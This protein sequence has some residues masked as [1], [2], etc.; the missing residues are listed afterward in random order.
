[1]LMSTVYVFTT[2]S[3]VKGDPVVLLHGWPHSW[4]QWHRVMPTLAQH[5]TVI[6]PD[7]RG[8]GDSSKPKIGYDSRTEAEDIYQLVNKL[9]FRSRLLG[10]C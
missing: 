9:G 4:Y 1:M 3:V 5:Y 10:W 8:F 6:V 2:Q 7:L